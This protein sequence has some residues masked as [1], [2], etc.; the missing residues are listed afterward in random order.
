MIFLNILYDVINI[1]TDKGLQN[2]LS[3]VKRVLNLIGMF[4]PIL[5]II[6]LVIIFTK[7]SE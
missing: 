7:I 3:I 6:S 1:C 2:I 4:G 5:C